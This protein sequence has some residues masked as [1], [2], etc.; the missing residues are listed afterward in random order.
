MRRR[1]GIVVAFHVVYT[2]LAL[3]F[4]VP[5]LTYAF[6]PGVALAEFAKLG[7]GMPI[8]HSEDS[9]V[10]RVLAVANVLTL[11]FCCTLIQVDLV[12]WFP[13]LTPLAFLKGA[14]AIGFLVAF[15]VEP[16]PGYLAGFA[17]DTVTVGA[18]VYF[19]VAARRA[20]PAP[21]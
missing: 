21:S 13:I 4:F 20:W 3:Q 11:A 14:A 12:R 9:V 19:A 1:P 2:V 15:L 5:A 6:A 16:F 10:W 17:L 18:M 7:F 8:P